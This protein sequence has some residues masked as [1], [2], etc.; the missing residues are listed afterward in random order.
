MVVELLRYEHHLGITDD[1]PLAL[2]R[3]MIFLDGVGR[4]LLAGWIIMDGGLLYLGC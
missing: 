1:L 4:V 3:G 2:F